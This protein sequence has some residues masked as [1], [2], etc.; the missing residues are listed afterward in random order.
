MR[1]ARVD[2][3]QTAKTRDGGLRTLDCL[4]SAHGPAYE[5]ALARR[6]VSRHRMALLE[7][8]RLAGQRGVHRAFPRAMARDGEAQGSGGTV[9]VLVVEPRRVVAAALLRDFFGE[10]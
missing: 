7:N 4:D 5:S 10:E 3:S 2:A 8:H 1:S 6:Q 9:V